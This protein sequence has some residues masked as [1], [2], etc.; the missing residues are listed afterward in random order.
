MIFGK[1]GTVPNKTVFYHDGQPTET[2]SRFIRVMF[3]PG[4]SL[5]TA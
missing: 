4:D 1:I 2:V 3:T 5:N